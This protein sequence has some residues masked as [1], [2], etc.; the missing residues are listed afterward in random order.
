M[1]R[2]TYHERISDRDPFQ[3]ATGGANDL[4][5]VFIVFNEKEENA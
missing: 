4:F 2:E 1:M 5:H 3:S